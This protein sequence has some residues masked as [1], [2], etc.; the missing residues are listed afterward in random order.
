MSREEEL[1]EVV[2]PKGW[3]FWLSKDD[4]FG[5]I[6]ARKKCENLECAYSA[7]LAASAKKLTGL[8]VSQEHREACVLK[9]PNWE[10]EL[11]RAEE[12]LNT[13]CGTIVATKKWA[14][15]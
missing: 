1:N 5:R 7:L 9:W 8:D 10:R 15:D 11:E 4:P 12:T 6:P 13:A 14:G 3:V 2:V